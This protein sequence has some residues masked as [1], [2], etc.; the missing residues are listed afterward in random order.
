L[1]EKVISIDDYDDPNPDETKDFLEDV[2]RI[3]GNYSA[4]QLSDITHRTGTPW[5][6]MHEKMGRT[7][8]PFTVIPNAMI[9]EHYKNLLDERSK[10]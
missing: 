4:G 10:T 5:D 8:K 7:I 2:W 6:Q 3:Y 1:E 9:R